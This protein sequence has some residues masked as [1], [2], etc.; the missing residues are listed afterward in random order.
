MFTD[1][2]T[3]HNLDLNE[4]EKAL[5][6]STNPISSLSTSSWILRTKHKNKAFYYTIYYI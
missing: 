1:L 4:I 5:D 3:E 2:I 6:L